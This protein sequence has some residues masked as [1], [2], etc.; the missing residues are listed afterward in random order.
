MKLPNRLAMVEQTDEKLSAAASL[1]F[2]RIRKG[3]LL[4]PEPSQS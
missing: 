4:T 3:R 2:G 1:E